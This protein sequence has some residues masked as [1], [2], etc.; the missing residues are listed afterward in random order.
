MK[1][2]IR[3]TP[4]DLRII[5][6]RAHEVGLDRTSYLVNLGTGREISPAAPR[7]LERVAALEH[8]LG[9]DNRSAV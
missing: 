5:D 2:T 4:D 1:S 7:L 9:L 6:E 8:V 3:C